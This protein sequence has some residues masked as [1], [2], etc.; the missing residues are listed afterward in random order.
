MLRSL[1]KKKSKFQVLADL[2]VELH[3]KLYLLMGQ[4]NLFD[5]T[6]ANGA[7]MLLVSPCSG[8]TTP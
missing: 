2:Q 8:A 7:A 6:V 1:K 3:V 5:L 4:Q